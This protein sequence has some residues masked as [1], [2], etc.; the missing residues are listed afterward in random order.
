MSQRKYE[1]LRKST[2]GHLKAQYSKA[3]M[4]SYI[5]N[6]C[7]ELTSLVLSMYNG[8]EN[9]KA[10]REELQT[11][12]PNIEPI[13]VHINN[14]FKA[15]TELYAALEADSIS[16]TPQQLKFTRKEYN[17]VIRAMIMRGVQME[18]HSPTVKVNAVDENEKNK[19]LSKKRIT[20]NELLRRRADEK[21]YK[22]EA[23]KK[24]LTHMKELLKFGKSISDI[25][26]VDSKVWTTQ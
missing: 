1:Q 9:M 11:E 12:A 7:V 18:L 19:R 13:I 3:H 24:Y 16:Y 20:N 23:R 4:N 15:Q 26:P 2:L 5:E 25:I 21:G 22:G 10:L 6:R 14:A 17:Y 8:K